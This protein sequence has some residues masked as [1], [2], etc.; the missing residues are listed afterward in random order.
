VRALALLL[1]LEPGHGMQDIEEVSVICQEL[2][3]SGVSDEELQPAFEELSGA[4]VYVTASRSELS[5]MIIEC[6][7]NANRWLRQLHILSLTL[8]MSLIT[9]SYATKSRDDYDAA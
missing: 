8:S 9:R 5:Q 7:S 2:I 4:V 6:M 1:W 3:A